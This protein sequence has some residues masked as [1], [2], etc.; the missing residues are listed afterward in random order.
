MHRIRLPPSAAQR[1]VAAKG[2]GA[3]TRVTHAYHMGC[4]AA[5]PALRMAA[6]F[7]SAPDSLRASGLKRVDVVH[8]EMCSLH[9]NPLH[10]AAEQLVV[11]S[12]FADGVHPPIRY[13]TPTSTRGAPL[14][15]R[16]FRKTSSWFQTPVSR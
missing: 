7:L 6:G 9:M 16:C 15:S 3:A 11:Q 14:P 5:F 4:Y 10:H 1:L 13:A 12:L 2:W 8:T